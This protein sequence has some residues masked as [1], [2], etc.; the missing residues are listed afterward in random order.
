[1]R[2]VEFKNSIILYRAPCGGA[3]YHTSL[4]IHYRRLITDTLFV[5]IQFWMGN[6]GPETLVFFV[7]GQKMRMIVQKVLLP[8]PP[9]S[10]LTVV[11]RT[12]LIIKIGPRKRF[13]FSTSPRGRHNFCHPTCG[14]SRPVARKV[15]DSLTPLRHQRSE[16]ARPSP[17]P[18]SPC[19]PRLHQRCVARARSSLSS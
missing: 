18:A 9:P 14:Q 19:E 13:H 11:M 12:A 16:I 17:S 3:H 1:M 6:T 8:F 10:P 15:G 7:I 4:L 2:S 5:D